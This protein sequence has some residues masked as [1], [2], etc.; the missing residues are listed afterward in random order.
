MAQFGLYKEDGDVYCVGMEA[1]KGHRCNNPDKCEKSEFMDCGA[2]YCPN[3][4]P[5]HFWHDGCPA[6]YDDDREGYLTS[7]PTLIAGL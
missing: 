7:V 3:K 2:L 6:C 4:A 5:E 1:F